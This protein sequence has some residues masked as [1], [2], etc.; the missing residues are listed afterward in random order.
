MT[1]DPRAALAALQAKFDA[2]EQAAAEVIRHWQTR[3]ERAEA[4][5]RWLDTAL[6]E[7]EARLKRRAEAQNGA[8]RGNAAQKPRNG[9][10]G[11]PSGSQDAEL[12]IA[13]LRKALEVEQAKVEDLTAR[14]TRASRQGTRPP[15]ED[16]TKDA[17]G[18]TQQAPR[19]AKARQELDSLIGLDSVKAEVKALVA[20]AEI[21]AERTRHG[22]PVP[23]M[24]L[25]LVL[26][27]N[28]GT[29]KTTVARIVAAL[30]HSI[31]LLKTDSVVE[32][33]RADLIGRYIGETAPK[34]RAVVERA[35][36]GVLFIDEAYGLYRP[37][38]ENDYGFEAIEELLRALEDHRD[39]LVVIL[40]GYE[41]PMQAMLQ[42]ANPGL[43]SRFQTAIHFPDYS[44]NELVAIFRRFC[45]EMH[46]Q[47]TEPAA[48]RVAAT[49]DAIHSARGD[50]FGNGRAV[51]N[52]FETCLRRQAERLAGASKKL[53]RDQ[54]STLSVKD[55]PEANDIR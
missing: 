46:V 6:K 47:L 40:A 8:G 55:V 16:S 25:H 14:L 10:D 35:L 3:A 24:S 19:A 21:R 36:D 39:R 49:L 27:G 44:P 42:G 9:P 22:L 28:P 17:A 34:T 37:K 33:T 29:G 13:A 32:V 41:E 23:S 18:K 26:T 52:L 54:L 48:S 11:P 1:T 50:R 12:T 38:S 30:Y 43:A 5:N 4:D 15:S 45:A 53:T 20:M 7:A 2:H 31:G 51:R